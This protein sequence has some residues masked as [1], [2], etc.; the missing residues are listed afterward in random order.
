MRSVDGTTPE[1]I[2]DTHTNFRQPE[3]HPKSEEVQCVQMRGNLFSTVNCENTADEFNQEKLM[4]FIC[5]KT[6]VI[7]TTES[8]KEKTKPSQINWED[9][10]RS[11]QSKIIFSN[12]PS[13][14]H[15]FLRQKNWDYIPLSHFC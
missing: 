7:S 1:I 2:W 12:L 5:E 14:V 8:P 9:K 11:S 10:T 3:P 13:K 4:N 6:S 15:E